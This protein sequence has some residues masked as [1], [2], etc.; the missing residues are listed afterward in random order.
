[1]QAMGD[2]RPEFDD[3]KTTGVAGNRRVEILIRL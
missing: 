3:T 1:V 2:A